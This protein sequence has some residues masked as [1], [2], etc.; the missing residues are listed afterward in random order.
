MIWPVMDAVRSLYSLTKFMMATPCWPSAGPIGGA[1]VALPAAICNLTYARIRFAITVPF[2]VERLALSLGLQEIELDRGLAAEE[3]NEH[4]HLAPLLVDLV[5]L[6]PEVGERTVV[7]PH[8]IAN[9][10]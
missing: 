2:V 4:L 6:A 5:D 7:D 9:L 1:G 10:E 8:R 3:G